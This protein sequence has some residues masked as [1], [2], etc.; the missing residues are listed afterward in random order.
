MDDDDD[1]EKSIISNKNNN[2]LKSSSAL[3]SSSVDDAQCANEEAMEADDMLNFSNLTLQGD[4]DD[5]DDDDD[6]D[7][8]SNS[9]NDD[10]ESE[11]VDDDDKGRNA[12]TSFVFDDEVSIN[13]SS[14][15]RRSSSSRSSTDDK[16]VTCFDSCGCWELDEGGRDFILPSSSSSSSDTT[17]HTNNSTVQWP[18]VRLPLPLYNKLFQHQ[19]IG[20]QWMASL[21]NNTIQ[22]GILA[23]DMGMGKTMSTLS[24]LGSLMRART[25]CNAIVVCPKSVV[26][27]WEREANLIV[28]NM[29]VKKATVYAV[30]SDMKSERRKRIFTEAFCS[31]AEA[32]RLVVTTYVSVKKESA[33]CCMETLYLVIDESSYSLLDVRYCYPNYSRD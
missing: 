12:D 28:K 24:Y 31:S 17:I 13:S 8:D 4:A 11:Y 18:K 19:R 1:E 23:D 7:Y 16:S 15:S 10:D 5:D 9:Y 32:P 6:A 27:S 20:V 22:G 14:I 3:K 30:T 33:A 25:I 21:H 2:N 26:R 29:C